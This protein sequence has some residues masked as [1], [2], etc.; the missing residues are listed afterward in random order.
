MGSSRLF[1][2]VE[3]CV[4]YGLLAAV[5]IVAMAG[6][7]GCGKTHFACEDCGT[8]TKAGACPVTP[9]SVYCP[10]AAFPSIACNCVLRTSWE[11]VAQAK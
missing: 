4:Y 7:S 8:C 6:F 10:G 1:W 9:T 3:K 5:L 11:C 2:R